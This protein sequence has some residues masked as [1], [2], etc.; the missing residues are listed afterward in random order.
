MPVSH[1][2]KCLFVHIPRTGGTSFRKMLNIDEEADGLEY[3]NTQ[4]MLMVQNQ[5]DHMPSHTV[6]RAVHKEHMCIKYM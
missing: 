6:P 4:G 3:L 2:Y 5:Q 1:K